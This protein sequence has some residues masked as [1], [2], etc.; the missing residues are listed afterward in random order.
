M[1]VR[2]MRD[3]ELDAV[4]ELWHETSASTYTFIAIERDRSLEDRRRFFNQNIAP[5]CV[6]WVVGHGDRVLGFMAMK[7]SSIDRLYVL[8]SAQRRGLGTALVEKAKLLHPTGLRLHTH[9]KN[10]K[11]CAFYEKHGFRPVRFGTSPPPENEPDVEY[12]WQRKGS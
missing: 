9:Q 3:H 12:H 11:A 2:E 5:Q 10:L 8:P 6:L 4:I 7:G 1:D